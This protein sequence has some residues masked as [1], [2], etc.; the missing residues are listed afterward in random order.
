[1]RESKSISQKVGGETLPFLAFGQQTGRGTSRFTSD[2]SLSSWVT[3]SPP[4]KVFLALPPCRR[5]RPVLLLDALFFLGGGARMLTS[6]PSAATP[7][8]PS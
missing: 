3:P 5:G 2:I 1:P 8:P 7:P 4:A 6:S